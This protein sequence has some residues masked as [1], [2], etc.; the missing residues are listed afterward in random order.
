MKNENNEDN[1]DGKFEDLMFI[2]I[3]SVEKIKLY[4][5]IEKL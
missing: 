2:E 5:V 3:K 1:L 4:N